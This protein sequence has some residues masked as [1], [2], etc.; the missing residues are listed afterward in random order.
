[1]NKTKIESY[2]N[3]IDKKLKLTGELD[4]KITLKC[5]RDANLPKP[6]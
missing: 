1:M 6:K 3:K 4:K 5:H 2:F